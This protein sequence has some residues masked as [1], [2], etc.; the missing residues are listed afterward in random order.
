MLF[1]RRS[2]S[3]PQILPHRRVLGNLSPFSSSACLRRRWLKGLFGR[4]NESEGTQTSLLKQEGIPLE[5]RLPLPGD[6][7]SRLGAG[8]VDIF[9]AGS[10]GIGAGTLVQALGGDTATT[11]LA[12]QGTALALWVLRDALSA[13]GN[14]SI[15]KRLF[16]LELANWDGSLPSVAHAAVR[17]AYFLALPLSQVHPLLEMVWTLVLVFDLSS[18]LFTQD[19]RKLGDYVL[20]TRVVDERPGR[21]ARVQDQIELAEMQDLQAEIEELTPVVSKSAKHEDGVTNVSSSKP[22]FES[23]RQ[24]V[25]VTPGLPSKADVKSA[26]AVEVSNKHIASENLQL[27]PPNHR[28]KS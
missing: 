17:N 23:V 18:I 28:P 26:S 1:L 3:V 24:E 6:P 19:A 15:G 21:A 25:T 9:I 20:G 5:L 22:W 7:M 8:L 12:A 14:R 4:N 13:D 16:K 2:A 10:A 27:H 11:S